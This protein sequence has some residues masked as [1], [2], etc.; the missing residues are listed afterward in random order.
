MSETQVEKPG[1]V[2][3]EMPILAPSKTL[4]QSSLRLDH[5]SKNTHRATHGSGRISGRGWP[6][7]ASVGG[8]ALGPEGV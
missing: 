3:L 2:N 7:L 6:C 8:A 5:Q 4:P 1:H